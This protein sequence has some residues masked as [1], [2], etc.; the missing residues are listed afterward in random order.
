MYTAGLIE[1]I[2]AFRNPNGS[3]FDWTRLVNRAPANPFKVALAEIGYIAIIPFA[4]IE[5]AL[6]AIAAIFLSGYFYLTDNQPCCRMV[7]W[8]LTSA[9]A[10]GW[11]IVNALIN[12]F[13]NDMI[14]K[15]ENALSTVC[16]G[17]I[18]QVRFSGIY[19]IGNVDDD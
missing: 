1:K 2:T 16:S 11:S 19:G 9:F 12:P 3:E 18:F 4:V 8:P 10:I 7:I 13:C 5:T 17:N 15:S 14:Q 6:S